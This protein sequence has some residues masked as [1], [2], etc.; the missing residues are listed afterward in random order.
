MYRRFC[1]T[2]G[3]VYA[4]ALAAAAPATM[5]HDLDPATTGEGIVHND[6]LDIAVFRQGIGEGR[7]LV[8]IGG[9]RSLA[10]HTASPFLH[11]ALEGSYRVLAIDYRYDPPGTSLCEPA[12]PPCF[13][14][15]RAQ[16]VFGIGKLPGL[17][18][19]QAESIL[20]RTEAALSTLD[21]TYPSEGWGTYLR[22]GVVRWDKVTISGFSQGAGL[23]AFLAKRVPV[24]RVVLLS[25]PWD[26]YDRTGTL[27][28][29]L[30]TSS[31][32]PPDRWWGVYAAAEPQAAWL[33]Q[34]YSALDIPPAHVFVL[35]GK[36][37]D[38]SNDTGTMPYHWS[39]V[40]QRFTPQAPNGSWLYLPIWRRVLGS[41][42]AAAP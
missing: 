16:K 14:K 11:A 12:A 26:H 31:A 9:G 27:A 28:S 41:E 8:F 35:H 23:A 36:P 2:S 30:A 42:S 34:A 25:S 37:R 21:R 13:E 19:T 39:V 6:A 33:A 17:E 5:E 32:T 24:A 3:L 20:H 7:L 10:A 4:L 38:A 40:G 15:Y 22:A 1:L 18:V 29:W